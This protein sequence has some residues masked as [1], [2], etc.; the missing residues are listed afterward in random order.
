MR[1]YFAWIGVR[2]LTAQLRYTKCGWWGG[3]SGLIPH[4]SGS[5][6]PLRVLQEEQA[7]DHVRPIV[8]A[9]A[10]EREEMV[11]C[12]KLTVPQFGGWTPAELAT[13]PISGE[14]ER[15]GDL[16]P[17]VARNV[18]ESHE[19]DDDGPRDGQALAPDRT[20]PVRLH[21]LGLAIDHETERAP[22]R[23]QRQRLE[24]RIERQA[25]HP[26]S[27]SAERHPRT[28]DAGARGDYARIIHGRLTPCKSAP[29][30]N[31]AG[32]PP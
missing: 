28:R 8:G 6:L 20:A 2:R 16:S 13:I 25:G 19:P 10:R 22:D 27:K 14:Q 1:M 24:R 23:D 21:D 3:R 7:V 11:P 15:V 32:P 5:A 31:E 30:L 4:S 12:E 26:T 17:E 9:P 29:W 18:D